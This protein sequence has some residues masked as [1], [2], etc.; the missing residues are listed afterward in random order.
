MTERERDTEAWLRR[1]IE[2]LGGMF[3]KFTSPGNDGV[4]D[5]IAMFPDGRIVFVEL[6]TTKG[7][8]ARIQWYQ[9]H[10]LITLHQQVCVIRGETAARNFLRDMRDHSIDSVDYYPDGDYPIDSLWE[11]NDR[12]EVR[13]P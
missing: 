1:R 7:R 9:I 2:D 11:F 6:K 10:R 13:H 3:L 12:K 4:P 8:L 5:R